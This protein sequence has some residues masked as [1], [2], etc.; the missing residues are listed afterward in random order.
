LSTN[1]LQVVK[2]SDYADRPGNVR[3]TEREYAHERGPILVGDAAV[4][5]ST[6]T[7]D[8]LEYLRSYPG[9]DI[10]A[11]VTGFYSLIY[12]KTGIEAA[13]DD[14]LSGEDSRL[15]VRRVSDLVTGRTLQGG[16]VVLT[17][18]PRAQRAAYEALGNRRGAVV[19][20]DPRTGAV[21]AMVSR[22]S[23][24]PSELTSHNP[25]QIRAAHARLLGDDTNPLLNRALQQSYPPG[26]L[27]KV[28][29]S[30]AALSTG[31]YHPE[32][33]IPAPDKLTLPGVRDP[34]ENFGGERCAADEKQ[35]LADAL[36]MSCNTAFAALGMS[37]GQDVLRR[38]A[39]KFGFNEGLRIPLTAAASRFPG[40]LDRP[41]TAQS[42]IGQR[43]VQVTPLQAA[44]I[45][46]AVA[47]H[48]TLM[49]PYLVSRMLSPDLSELESA[50]PERLSQAMSPTVA[51][52]LTTMMLGVVEHGTG[53]AARISGI[54]VAGKTGTA[55]HA[56][57][58]APH[59]W[60]A[61]FA[62]AD[63]PTIAIAVVVEDGGSA[64]S[65]A[66]G[67][68]VAAP[69]ARAVLEAMLR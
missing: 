44:M 25:K 53:T 37:L 54:A 59:A 21:L 7:D 42:A 62:P 10:Y 23:Y 39:E 5:K 33:V 8:R 50:Q 35:T 20:L 1:Y 46:A 16:A 63:K 38:Q 28:V 14:V 47:N 45:V 51:A 66:T 29:T 64:G 57:G 24:N 19:A 4:A 30:A 17:I 43:D 22:P 26:S 27:F 13:R 55:Q 65:D 36:R 60:F 2:A 18:D 48:G 12:G 9:G 68:R 67:G 15:F 52:E 61:C 34:L 40:N 6:K 3:V 69:I 32:S 31:R 58:A 49:K 11:P 56:K 41:S